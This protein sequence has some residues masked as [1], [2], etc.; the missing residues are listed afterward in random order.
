MAA[1]PCYGN[2]IYGPSADAAIPD[3]VL[4]VIIPATH[5]PKAEIVPMYAEDGITVM[6][7]KYTITVNTI[8]YSATST[9]T[10]LEAEVKRIKKILNTPRLMLKIKPVGLGDIPV[11][12]GGTSS[13]P[14]L[15]AGPLPQSV[16][17]EPVVSNN[18]IVIV[19]TVVTHITHC[20]PFFGRQL[21][22]LTSQ[23]EADVDESG[24]VDFVVSMVYRTRDPIPNK[25]ALLPLANVLLRDATK[26]FQ[27][28]QVKKR[29]SLSPDQR[30][31]TLTIQLS[32]VRSPN[33][34][35]PN[36][37]HI[38][39]T[40]T[41]TS[42]LRTKGQGLMNW[43]R[44]IAVKITL[45]PRIHKSWTW[46]VFKKILRERFRNLQQLDRAKALAGGEEPSQQ[47]T[48]STRQKNW[49]LLLKMKITDEMYSQSVGFQ[50]D[51]LISTDLG[52]LLSKTG[53]FSRIN[54]KY[55]MDPNSNPPFTTLL[56]Q[57]DN[58][59]ANA[60]ISEQWFAWQ[61]YVNLSYSGYYQYENSGA[62]A[63]EQCSATSTEP[64]LGTTRIYPTR[65]A[66]FE[67]D[68]DGTIQS[69]NTPDTANQKINPNE[70]NET[71]NNIV[72]PA[73]SWVD[74]S[75]EFTFHEE[76]DNILATYLQQV[77]VT[78]YQDYAGGS[79]TKNTTGF[80]IGNTTND[81]NTGYLPPEVFTRGTASYYVRMK[82]FALRVGHK[83]PTPVA[84]SLNGTL[85]TRVGPARIQQEQVGQSEGNPVYLAMWD[86]VY[87]VTGRVHSPDIMSTLK[88]TGHPSAYV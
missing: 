3:P 83:I 53:I 58:G 25:T 63:V 57:T 47:Q 88:S 32:E 82:G 14:D 11:I 1:N 6:Y 68:P 67:S 77:P 66:S 54:T 48:D 52:T 23:I 59:A 4:N 87:A 56:E 86:V 51:Y 61:Y 55:R 13:S 17:V 36:V 44:S 34:L 70:P 72:N 15:A 19:W 65:L 60:T 79:P 33:A 18:A 40:D 42:G 26:S 85:L 21:V 27:G 80:Q 35:F 69:P 49:F 38:E 84:T 78:Y 30:T 37:Q 64:T 71:S 10:D 2:I 62:I 73:Y 50:F 5:L 31:A 12:N 39:G 7:Y 28:M 75:N 41:I 29:M 76:N 24:F 16:V 20:E 81:P 45:P 46:V 22:S 43:D 8:I 9:D 74:Y